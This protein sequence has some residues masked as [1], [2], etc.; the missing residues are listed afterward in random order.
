MGGTG[1]DQS[2]AEASNR[3]RSYPN[4]FAYSGY[5]TGSSVSTRN[6]YGI[7][8]SASGSSSSSAYGLF[9]D[10]EG[11]NPGTNY[12]RKWFGK[13]VRCVAGV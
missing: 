4:N 8:W 6:S 13:V 7:Y 11:V 5:V 1:A 10:S 9:F 2:T 12:G 3:W